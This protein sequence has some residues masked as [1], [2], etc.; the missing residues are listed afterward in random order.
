MPAYGTHSYC[1]LLPMF[2]KCLGKPCGEIPALKAGQPL[3]P[4]EQFLHSVMPIS[5]GEPEFSPQRKREG[6]SGDK[7]REGRKGREEGKR[8]RK[9]EREKGGRKE[10]GPQNL[11]GIP[12]SSFVGISSILVKRIS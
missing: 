2:Q 4:T 6:E 9:R 12:G 10:E 8:K 5:K 11:T 7:R 3:V 1:G